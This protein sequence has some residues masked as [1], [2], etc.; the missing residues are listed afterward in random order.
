M[1]ILYYDCFSGISGDM[2]LAAMA[3]LGVNPDYLT[4]ELKKLRLEGYSISF[5]TDQRKG[6]TGLRAD[7]NLTGEETHD[8]DHDHDHLH[9]HPHPHTHDHN[10]AHDHLTNTSFTFKGLKPQT[11]HTHSHRNYA[12][13]KKLINE[14]SL[15]DHVKQ[16]SIAI[17]QKVAEAEALIHGKAVDEVHFHEVGAVD[18]IVDIVGAAICID[19]LK[20]DRIICSPVQLGGGFVNCAH[21]RFPVPAPA[22]LEILKGIPVRMGAVQVETTT[23]TGAAIVA[24]LADEFTEN[25]SLNINKV[26]YGIGHRDNPV[27]NVL[28]VCLAEESSNAVSMILECNIDDMN[29]ELYE[30]VMEKLFTAG[31]DDVWF[32]PVIMKKTRPATKISVLCR[33]DLVKIVETILLTETSTLGVRKYAVEKTM[34]QRSTQ[35]VETRWGTVRVKLGYL[36]GKAIKS[37]PEYEDCLK[38]SRENQVPIQEI[39]REIALK[40][41]ENN[42]DN[43]QKK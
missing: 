20:P 22:T 1:K 11:T 29:P 7:V 14:S 13:I 4:N 18:S 24:A 40:L 28:R 16:L 5:V 19:Y 30:Y 21:G 27:P 3:G 41:T 2:N 9:D 42:H 32:Q 39:Y 33:N 15:N 25:P 35:N 12:D 6:I 17:F 8:H 34:L 26:A 38:L 10:H 37:K 36:D 31:A 43:K 23:P